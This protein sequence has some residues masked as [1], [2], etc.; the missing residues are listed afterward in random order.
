MVEELAS[1]KAPN[2]G[3]SE[4]IMYGKIIFVYKPLINLTESEKRVRCLKWKSK[5]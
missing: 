4:E 5:Y 2:M 3:I 1:E